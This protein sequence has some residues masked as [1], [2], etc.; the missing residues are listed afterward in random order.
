M[1]KEFEILSGYN[2][3]P[4]FYID[5]LLFPLNST[6]M[7]QRVLLDGLQKGTNY[8]CIS[9]GFGKEKQIRDK[10]LHN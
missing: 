2:Y 1:Q 10:V 3:P 5:P 6:E 9:K 8:T 4:P 7:V